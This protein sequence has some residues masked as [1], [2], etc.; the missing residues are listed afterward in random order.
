MRVVKASSK[1]LSTRGLNPY[2]FMEKAG[3]TCYKSLDHITDTSAVKFVQGLMKS[4]HTAMLEHSHIILE[5][6][7]EIAR[8]F[9]DVIMTND[10]DVEGTKIRISN[11]FNIT[12][13]GTFY[14]ISGSF[15]A[16]ASLFENNLDEKMSNSAK[17][18]MKQ[19]H[20]EYPEVFRDVKINAHNNVVLLTRE[21]FIKLANRVYKDD[22]DK[23]DNLIRRH[24]THTVLFVCDRGVTHE[25]VRHRPA[26]FA[27]ESTRYC[28]YSKDKF[29]NEIT[30]VKPCFYEKGSEEYKVWYEGC[31]SDEKTYFKLLELGCSAQ[32]ARDNLPTSVKTELIMTATEEEWQHVINLRYH[33][34]TGKPH[35]QMIESMTL[36][37]NELCK[38][39]NNRLA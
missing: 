7:V 30:V 32:Q 15:R 9:I 5:T 28:N 26:S 37:Y 34:T 36:I 29:G 1:Y 16:F 35:P 21:S 23:R 20:V 17:M 24:L 8:D 14:I 33:G 11:Y 18:I 3:R 31:L 19:A 12:N 4:G 39:S 6:S 22:S 25:F 38:K 2:Q 10:F 27:Q 13:C